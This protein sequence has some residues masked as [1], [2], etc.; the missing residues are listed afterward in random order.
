[1]DVDLL[2]KLID[3][4]NAKI[5]TA[6]AA[7]FVIGFFMIIF[8]MVSGLLDAVEVL[9]REVNISTAWGCFCL[10]FSKSVRGFFEPIVSLN[11]LSSHSLFSG[12]FIIVSRHRSFVSNTLQS[13]VLPASAGRLPP[14]RRYRAQKLSAHKADRR[15]ISEQSIPFRPA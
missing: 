15:N 7:N 2:Q 13:Y 6:A 1:M 14:G 12:R 10:K 8:L 3:D 9:A 5:M 11:T 4:I